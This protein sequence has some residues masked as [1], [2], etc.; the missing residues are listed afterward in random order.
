MSNIKSVMQKVSIIQIP[1]N[2][3]LD[4]VVRQLQ[5]RESFVDT[6]QELGERIY[7]G[8]VFEAI[9][10]ELAEMKDSPL[11]PSKKVVD[12]IDELAGMID[13]EYIQITMI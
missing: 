1:E 13:A 7:T 2:A 9:A 4:G 10:G 6:D 3:L 12:Q 11:Y 5:G 8:D